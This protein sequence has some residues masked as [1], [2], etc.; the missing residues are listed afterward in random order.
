MIYNIPANINQTWVN[1]TATI[2]FTGDTIPPT[3]ESVTLDAYT[4][5]ANATIHVTVNATDNAG[6]ISITADGSTLI[7]GGNNW[8]GE[9]KVPSTATPGVYSVMIQAS[10][11]ALNTAESTVAYTIVVPQ[12][13]WA[14]I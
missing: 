8:T 2:L 3:I 4:T 9:L 10:D 5:I 7:E 12:A 6:V 1:D 11:A 14:S 13:E